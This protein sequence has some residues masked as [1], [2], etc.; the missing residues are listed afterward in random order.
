MTARPE[1]VLIIDDNVTNLGVLS[2]FLKLQGYRIMVAKDG[3]DGIDKAR[4]GIPDIIL[5]D[6]QMPG[7]DGFE[8]CRIMKTHPDIRDIPVLF[9]T[10]LQDVADK[11]KGFAAGGVDYI[12]KPLQEP[13]VL[14][15]VE[16]HLRLR[17]LQREVEEQNRILDERVQAQV[18]EISDSQIATIIALAELAESRDYETGSHL[19][20]VGSCSRLLAETLCAQSSN[21]CLDPSDIDTLELASSLHDIGKV[22]VP[23]NILKKKGPERLTQGEFDIIKRHTVIGAQT[24]EA[25]RKRYPS[26]TLINAGISIARSHHERWNGTGYPDG[27]RGESIPLFARIVALADVYDALRSQ[28]VY[29]AAMTHAESIAIIAEGSGVQFDPALVQAFMEASLRIRTMWDATEAPME[30]R[31]TCPPRSPD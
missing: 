12:T 10:A 3:R 18:K 25:V 4:A 7:I 24:L 19:Q 9:I 2:G 27:L 16:T 29:K 13:E 31:L 26:N 6:V 11:V 5:L 1:T 17:R 14:A 21:A 15:R 22:G 30:S 20:R 8:T 28:R 23:D